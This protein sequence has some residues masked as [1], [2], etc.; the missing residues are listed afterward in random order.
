[1][2]LLFCPECSDVIKLSYKKRFCFCKKSYGYIK[3]EITGVCDVAYINSVGMPLAID[4][5]DLV[6]AFN[7]RKTE[8]SAWVIKAWVL[9][10][11]MQVCKVFLI[12]EKK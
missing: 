1:M 9:P 5:N 12:K 3:D 4:N 6:R 8:D 7:S 11:S 10:M 2:K